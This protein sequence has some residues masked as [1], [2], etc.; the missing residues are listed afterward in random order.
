[1]SDF[2]AKVDDL[3]IVESHIQRVQ[4]L[5]ESKSKKLLSRY[6]EVRQELRDRLDRLPE[7]SFSAQQLRGILAQIDGALSAMSTSLFTG[8]K[9]AARELAL[10][11]IEDQITEI[12]KFSQVFEGA[13]VGI[14]INAQVIA[15]D[16]QN[17]LLNRYE[18]SID[19]YTEDV[20][21]SLITTLSNES[22]MGSPVSKIVKSMGAFFQGEEWKLQRIARTELH[23]V[24]NLGK[25]NGMA[26][27]RDQVL[28]DLKKTLVHPMD[29]RTGRDSKYAA[30]LN[31]IAEIDEPFEYRWRGEVRR[32]MAPPD[33]P[34]DRSILVPYRQSWAE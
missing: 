18:A 12:K 34:N 29:S 16:T 5:E 20:R 15:S 8:L 22:L 1:M 32:Y 31:L 23:N 11:G 26:E 14:N 30:S 2:F 25:M 27:T 17:F 19:A 33:R 10:F 9:D 3:G 28:P 7:D 24:Y 4:R 13:V 6:R 21:A